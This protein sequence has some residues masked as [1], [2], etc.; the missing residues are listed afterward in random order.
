MFRPVLGE[1]FKNHHFR[2]FQIREL[3]GSE[4][5]KIRELIGSKYFKKSES[6]N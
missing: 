4:H 3:T 5:F 2:V 6:K 1:N